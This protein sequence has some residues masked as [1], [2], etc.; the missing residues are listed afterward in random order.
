MHLTESRKSEVLDV[1][2]KSSGIHR[3]NVSDIDMT[4]TNGFVVSA[5]VPVSA[6][7]NLKVIAGVVALLAYFITLLRTGQV[8]YVG[9]MTLF[10]HAFAYAFDSCLDHILA[11]DEKAD[12]E[13]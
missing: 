13:G 4:Q 5:I 11:F 3:R 6:R 2:W 7:F 1:E 8:D 9:I 12:D 10:A